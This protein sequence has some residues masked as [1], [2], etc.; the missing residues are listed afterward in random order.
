MRH[1]RDRALNRL[2]QT[3]KLTNEGSIRRMTSLNHTNSIQLPIEYVTAQEV[4]RS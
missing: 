1:S 3:F 2:R 4:S